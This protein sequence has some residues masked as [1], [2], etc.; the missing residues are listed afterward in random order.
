[1]NYNELTQIM[2]NWKPSRIENLD[3]VPLGD[4]PGDKVEIND[5]HIKKANIIFPKLIEELKPVLKSN[6]HSK[7]V[8]GICGGSGVGKS[9]TASLISY[10]LESIGIGSYTL[11]GDNYPH[12]IPKQNDA[13]RLRIYRK[14]GMKGLQLRGV[15]TNE[16]SQTAREL[17][18]KE[19]DSNSEQVSNFPWLCVY[20]E[21]ASNGLRNY[22]G[23]NDEINFDELSDII[24]QF[25]NGASSVFLKRMGREETDLWYESVDFSEKN[26]IIIEW[27][28]SNSFRLKG[29]DIPVFLFSTPSE[30]LEHRKARAR[31]KGVDSS[32]VTL[33]LKLEQD[34]LNA[35]AV[36]AKIILTKSGEIINFNEFQK[37]AIR[38]EA[39]E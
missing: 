39:G 27:T 37:A 19:I 18:K 13:E 12:R 34:M 22:L 3:L 33:V 30:T 6:P 2:S 16:I 8:I 23:S 17:Q 5:T 9:E 28:H 15:L 32:F 10:Y 4:M 20:Q 31:D 14:S 35:Q 38:E 21:E 36:K 7:A 25:K 1:M 11:S 24:A 26:V 29:V